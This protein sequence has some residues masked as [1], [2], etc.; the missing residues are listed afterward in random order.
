[1]ILCAHSTSRARNAYHAARTCERFVYCIVKITRLYD[2]QTWQTHLWWKFTRCAKVYG[3]FFL[4]A[5][6]LGWQ[7]PSTWIGYC[8]DF[9]IIT[10]WQINLR[11]V[12]FSFSLYSICDE[13]KILKKGAIFCSKRFSRVATAPKFSHLQKAATSNP[14]RCT[15]V[16]LLKLQ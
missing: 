16:S 15:F 9:S 12:R 3:L 8:V 13:V 10:Y 14:L 11:I 5:D 2:Y 4:G 6:W 1:M 7:T